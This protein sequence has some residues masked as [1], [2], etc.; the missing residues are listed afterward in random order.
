M[1]QF[2]TGPAQGFL[3]PLAR[4]RSFW[5]SLEYAR[6]TAAEF[7]TLNALSDAELA[8]MGLTRGVLKRHIH[9]KHSA[10]IMMGPQAGW[11]D[12]DATDHDAEQRRRRN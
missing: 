3:A 2:L 7:A 11:H 12:P 8:R 4:L 1:Q 10:R 5:A 9:Q 6:A